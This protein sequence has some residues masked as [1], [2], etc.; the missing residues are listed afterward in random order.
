M[1]ERVPTPSPGHPAHIDLRVYLADLQFQSLSIGVDN[2][3]FDVFLSP[4]F[5]ETARKY[6]LET[7]RQ[8]AAL[9]LFYGSEWK[10]FRPPETGAFKKA[11]GDLLQASLTKAKFEKNIEIDL[12]LQ[13]AL[14]KFFTLELTAQ[15]LNLVLECKE[16]IR[17]RGEVFERSEM[18]HVL[19]A[20]LAELQADRPNVVRKVGQTVF[21]MLA[22]LEDSTVARAR[23]ALFGEEYRETY[24]LFR[25]RLLFVEGGR[26]DYLFLEHYVLLGN[27]VRDQDRFEILDAVLI[28]FLRDFVLA[29]QGGEDVGVLWKTYEQMND[30]ALSHRAEINRLEEER[31][32][33]L[34]QL[35]QGDSLLSLLARPK[36]PA[37]IRANLKDVQ[38]RHDFLEQKLQELQGPLEAAKLKVEEVT[39][40]YNSQMGDFL[41]Q[42]ENARRLFDRQW[43]GEEMKADAGVRE[44]LLE[45]WVNRLG[46]RDLLFSIIAAYEL[47]NVHLDFCPPVHLQQLKK[48][49][50]SR[51]ELKRVEEI[52][53]QFPARNFSLSRLEDL[54][55]NVRK[56]PRDQ[57][58]GV[59]LR[60][61]EDFMRMRRD[62]RNLQKMVG[63][64]ERVNLIRVER[65]RDLSRMN[66]SLYEYLLPDEAKPAEDRIL[67]HVIIK[68]DVRGSTKMTQDLLAR[69]L[70]PASHFS[71]NLYEPMRRI[72]DRFGAAKVFIEGDAIILAIYETESNRERQRAVAKACLLGCEILNV[73]RSYN[74]KEE[75]KELPRLELGVGV[76]FQNSPPTYWM[77]S[78]SRIMIS[79]AINLSDRLSSCSK[80]ARRMVGEKT[81]PFHLFVFQTM[82]DGTTEE[83]V[84]E[85]LIRY[86]LNGVQLNEE[87]FAK[88][89]QEISL[90][91]MRVSTRL[92]WGE[93]TMALYTG[94]VPIGETL[95]K[96]VV[97]KGV[98]RQMLT[99]SKIGGSGTHFYYEV[100]SD[101]GVAELL[102]NAP[103]PA[104]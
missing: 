40:K 60:F 53:K 4:K 18:A 97:R 19:K 54:S 65:T 35:D 70:N 87:G 89:Q 48:A 17:A 79:K 32:G 50:V 66:S 45:E 72:L 83:D 2:L 25:N 6:L 55:R 26:D 30:K 91:E 63:L 102:K 22:E 21:Q 5:T 9:A 96:I 67:S 7:L 57:V 56:Y 39:A 16:F 3:H 52:V 73:A 76:A 28:E 80:A 13:V 98:V 61:A 90:R 15:F 88:L 29:G 1:P 84:E 69:G 23:R 47:R 31:A 41:N 11:L 51:E 24:D 49:L 64:M 59:A 12:L 46:Q 71:L 38:K 20:R 36:D 94:E 101:P 62:M 92:P 78:D 8:T 86:N 103:P 33:L 74:S 58:R 100:C 95:E 68:A 27:F 10:S 42:P 37:A 44:R 43:G 99:G 93:E 34:R 14:R 104:K 81:G 85:F 77:D 75:M 82:M